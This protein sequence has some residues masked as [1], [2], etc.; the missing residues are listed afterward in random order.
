M[1]ARCVGQVYVG[2]EIEG[3]IV[4]TNVSGATLVRCDER[5]GRRSIAT[6][7]SF[8]PGRRF[9]VFGHCKYRV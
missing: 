4:F 6:C 8:I 2:F 1:Q 9:I 7:S 5:K 3:A